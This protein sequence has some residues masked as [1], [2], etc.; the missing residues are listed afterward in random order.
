MKWILSVYNDSDDKKLADYT[1]H[2]ELTPEVPTNGAEAFNCYIE[3]TF[4]FWRECRGE[5]MFLGDVGE[6]LIGPEDERWD[7]VMMIIRQSGAQLLLVF[8]VI[9]ITWRVSV[10][11]LQRLKIHAVCL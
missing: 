8:L 1:A 5:V 7:L 10:I 11:V 6:Y 2:S 3:H 9:R 4:H